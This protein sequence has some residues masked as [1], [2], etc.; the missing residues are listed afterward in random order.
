[1]MIVCAVRPSVSLRQTSPGGDGEKR[2]ER[3]RDAEISAI[4]LVLI[5]VGF[6]CFAKSG[7]ATRRKEVQH[8][9]TFWPM[10][11]WKMLAKTSE[12]LGQSVVTAVKILIIHDNYNS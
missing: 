11:A 3:E 2:R 7:K 1:M 5:L 4:L 12:Q 8:R 9:Q 6:G 10:D